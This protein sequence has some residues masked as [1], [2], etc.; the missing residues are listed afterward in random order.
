MLRSVTGTLGPYAFHITCS[1]PVN[2][3][4]ACVLHSPLGALLSFPLALGLSFRRFALGLRLFVLP[5]IHRLLLS[6]SDFGAAFIFDVA[7]Q[8]IEVNR[9]QTLRKT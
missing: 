2:V 3:F 1:R 7:V 4:F 8:V 5:C 9:F 6:F